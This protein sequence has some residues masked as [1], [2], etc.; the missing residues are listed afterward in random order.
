MPIL[1]VDGGVCRLAVK[2][3]LKSENLKR[4]DFN[5]LH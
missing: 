3:L 1:T 4:L 2:A 5:R